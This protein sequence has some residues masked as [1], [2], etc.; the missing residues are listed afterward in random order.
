MSLLEKKNL[1]FPCIKNKTTKIQL[2]TFPFQILDVTALH[3]CSSNVYIKLV[4]YDIFFSTNI[5]KLV[6]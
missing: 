5:Q 3:K 6:Y 2:N 4:V 1:I